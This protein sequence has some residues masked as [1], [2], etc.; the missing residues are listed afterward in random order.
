MRVV[1]PPEVWRSFG[2]RLLVGLLLLILSVNPWNPSS[3]FLRAQ[4]A[5]SWTVCPQGPPWCSF[6]SI[7]QAIDAASPGDVIFIQPG[8]YQESL[9]IRKSLIIQGANPQQVI[10]QG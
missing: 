4:A 7:Q 3:S 2:L 5:Q 8:F 6:N 1:C 10:I 9:I